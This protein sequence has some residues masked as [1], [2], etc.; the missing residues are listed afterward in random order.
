MRA[1][2]IHQWKPWEKST[3]PKTEK[4]KKQSAVR[5]YKG[6]LRTEIRSISKVL[7]DQRQQLA[8]IG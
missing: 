8:T 7:R 2:M 1:K 3:G 5:G 4:G 6:G